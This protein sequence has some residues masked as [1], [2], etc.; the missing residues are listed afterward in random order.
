MKGQ[1]EESQDRLNRKRDRT[2]V[3][4]GGAGSIDGK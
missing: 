1:N 3:K 2:H 4:G